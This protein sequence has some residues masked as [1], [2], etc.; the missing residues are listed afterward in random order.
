MR[1]HAA[2]RSLLIAFII[3]TSATLQ[4]SE[5]E[6][7]AESAR[8]QDVNPRALVIINPGNPTG[9]CLAESNMQEVHFMLS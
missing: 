7:L 4:V 6:S 9:Q 1:T 3:A 5:L 8:N 2:A